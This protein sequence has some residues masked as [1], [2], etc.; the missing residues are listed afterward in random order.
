MIE[1]SPYA[2]SPQPYIDYYTKQAGGGG[3]PVFRGAAVQRGHGLLGSLVKLAQPLLKPAARALGKA[4]LRT[5]VNVVK[6]VWRGTPVK[7]AVKR[8]AL[9][10]GGRLLTQAGRHTQHMMGNMPGTRPIKRK[11]RRAPATRPRRVRR[12]GRVLSHPSPRTKPRQS[13]RDIFS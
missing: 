2:C 7:R 9:E 4:A 13:K 12:A 6:D 3:I 8:R 10:A 5:G 1:P 11:R